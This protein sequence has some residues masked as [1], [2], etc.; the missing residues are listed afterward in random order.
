MILLRGNGGL[1]NMDNVS[2]LC[3]QE[4]VVDGV[5]KGV[6]CAYTT[7]DY[8]FTIGVYDTYLEAQHQFNIL[9]GTLRE[10]PDH[11]TIINI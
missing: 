1:V 5:K 6:I 10:C 9:I 7:S 4:I 2:T 11:A 8:K 3:P